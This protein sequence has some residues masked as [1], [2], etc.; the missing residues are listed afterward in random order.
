MSYLKK[1]LI[2]VFCVFM[3]IG[4]QSSQVQV[5]DQD[6]DKEEEPF[7]PEAGARVQVPDEPPRDDS[8]D[9]DYA[10]MRPNAVN[11][12]ELTV[13]FSRHDIEL[14][15]R[16]SYFASEAQIFTAIYEG[17]FSYHPR[18]LEPVPAL[19]ERWELS[20]DKMQW[21]FT[22]RRGARFWNGD[23]VRAED[24]R[25]AWISLLEPE[26][27]SPYSSMFDVIQGARDY[28]NGI[29]RDPDSVGIRAADQR[30]LVINLSSPASFFPA[31]LCHHSFS[32]I[33]SSMLNNNHWAPREKQTNWNPP[34]SNGPFRIV[35]MNED[36]IVMEKNNYYWDQ[37]NVSLKKLVIA[38]T[39]NADDAAALW[40]SG[41]ARWIAGD[42][43]IDALTD[44]S[45]IQ[46]NVMFATHYYFI[47]SSQPPFNDHRVR[48]AMALALPYDDIRGNYYLPAE[49]LIYPITGY[50]EV[51]GINAPNNV[52]ARR[53]MAEAGY[54]NTYGLPEIVIR[55]VPSNDAARVAALMANAWREAL[56]LN[57]R[58]QVVPFALYYDSMKDDGYTVASTTWIGDFA[59]PYA[60]LQ[61]WRRDSNLN[62]A[63]LNDPD[64]ETLIERSMLQEGQARLATLAEAEKLLLDRGVILPIY[65]SPALNIIDTGE[66]DGWYPNALDIHPFK[67]IEFRTFRPLPGVAMLIKSID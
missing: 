24:F 27:D 61:M 45:G 46:I 31:M 14:D 18:T 63:R 59:D 22:I 2:I 3:I 52:E 4:C 49:T 10:E 21:T 30:T 53:L 67:Y 19:A 12:E 47:R 20:E 13:A 33:H 15:F 8:S 5:Q 55:I 43:N 26:R 25:A 17:L 16:K 60:F 35:T 34:V 23:A 42:V 62:D 64:Y 1:I 6:Q 36:N 9:R 66:L 65:Y 48:R 56:G 29:N 41:S 32:P 7:V 50:P 54:A 57:V 37:N 51:K 11:L 38:F 58:I 40:N 39:D 28:R 44:R